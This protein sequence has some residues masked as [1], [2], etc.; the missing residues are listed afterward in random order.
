MKR[1]V[2]SY[3][4]LRDL[5]VL[6]GSNVLFDLKYPAAPGIVGDRLFA[7]AIAEGTA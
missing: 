1:L 6:G 5:A 4:L 7:L 3:T 2:N